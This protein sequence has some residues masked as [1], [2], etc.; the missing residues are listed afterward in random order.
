MLETLGINTIVA[1]L[2]GL[3]GYVLAIQRDIRQHERQLE[4]ELRLTQT[5]RSSM[6]NFEDQ[7]TKTTVISQ[8]EELTWHVKEIISEINE[9]AYDP[10]GRL[11]YQVGLSHLMDHLVRSW[12]FSKIPY[13]KHG[14]FTTDEWQALN[15][16][17]PKLNGDYRLVEPDEDVI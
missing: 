3:V 14:S 16:S 15:I 10:G 5:L 12:H 11:S 4:S 6:T 17:I 7:Q 2:S 1:L 8:L 13:D 9:G